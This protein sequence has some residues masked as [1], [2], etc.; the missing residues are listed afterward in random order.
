MVKKGENDRRSG[1]LAVL[2]TT[3]EAHVLAPLGLQ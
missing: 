1:R 2:E 3:E